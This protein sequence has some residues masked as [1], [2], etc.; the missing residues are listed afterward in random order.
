MAIMIA[1]DEEI[2][3][4]DWAVELQRRRGGG[5]LELKKRGLFDEVD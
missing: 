1:R 5:F 4:Q 2:E 3:F